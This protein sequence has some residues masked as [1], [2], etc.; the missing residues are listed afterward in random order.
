MVVIVGFTV[1]F[2]K[3]SWHQFMLSLLG[4]FILEMIAA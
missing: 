1:N 2:E 4:N 3:K